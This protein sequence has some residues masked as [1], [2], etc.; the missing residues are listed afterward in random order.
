MFWLLLTA[1]MSEM[2]QACK[3][4][5]MCTGKK[6]QKNQQQQEQTKI[7]VTWLLTIGDCQLRSLLMIV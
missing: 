2:K 4:V 5:R 7:C 1:F 6:K 3:G